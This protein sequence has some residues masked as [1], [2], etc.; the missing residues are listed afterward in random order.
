MTNDYGSHLSPTPFFYKK[1]VM[2]V[3]FDVKTEMIFAHII[4]YC[5]HFSHVTFS[6]ASTTSLSGGEPQVS[7][8]TGGICYVT[9]NF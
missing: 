6:T 9:I 8:Q 7:R 2:Q 5:E 4:S 3:I 1:I